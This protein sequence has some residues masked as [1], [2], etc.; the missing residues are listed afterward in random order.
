M[1]WRRVVA[2]LLVL[3]VVLLLAG[4]CWHRA[5]HLASLPRHWADES[6]YGLMAQ[7]LIRGEP[8]FTRTS[9]GNLPDPFFVT[10]LVPMHLAFGA[11]L[12][13]LRATAVL[14]SLVALALLWRL[15]RKVLDP[16]TAM[17][18]T[19]LLAVT[20]VAIVYSR[21]ACEF[22]QTP[23]IGV[24]AAYWSLRGRGRALLLTLLAGLLVHPTNIF[25]IPFWLPVYLVQAC[26]SRAGNRPA[27]VGAV[28][29]GLVSV[30]AVAGPFALWARSN[31][32][33]VK[34]ADDTR[35]PLPFLENFARFLV[36]H[37]WPGPPPRGMIW[38]ALG[39]VGL[40]ACLGVRRLVRRRQWERL[41]LLVG[42][43]AGLAAFDI[44]AGAEVL[45]QLSRYGIV[46]LVPTALA[47][48]V[49]I[50]ALLPDG[51]D[52]P[53][54]GWLDW[55]FS[56]VLLASW[57]L[58]IVAHVNF[59]HPTC[60]VWDCPF[61][62][63]PRGHDT[64]DQLLDRVLIEARLREQAGPGTSEGPPIS[65]IWAQE[66]FLNGLI[67]EYLASDRPGLEV[68]SLLDQRT[69]YGARLDQPDALAR[70][71][72]ALRT[73]LEAGDY[74]VTEDSPPELGGNLL[75][76]VAGRSI[77]ISRFR[78]WQLTMP[79]GPII[80]VFRLHDIPPPPSLA[81]QP[82]EAPRR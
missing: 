28:L 81:R 46:L 16:T 8:V 82:T 79:V 21:M 20:P 1:N 35:N 37:Y 63:K 30:A 6:Y 54:A 51:L 65:R 75:P 45:M 67:L 66:Y 25:L 23:L 22:C 29:A 64:Y 40:L 74:V 24:L 5:S 32:N 7:A 61:L 39:L 36:W 4:A 26:R 41:A 59:V 57:A 10:L 17:A 53:R 62:R 13:V 34:F 2:V 15:G 44:Q 76:T 3:Q 19:L 77:P 11:S 33:V 42:W 55:R 52:A 80:H 60:V 58:L 31:A 72:E 71:S 27:Q 47:A 43:A 56:P 50:R 68:Y 48:S 12:T 73:V 49:L 14:C 70:E 69:G 18:A 78:H 9:S 38:S